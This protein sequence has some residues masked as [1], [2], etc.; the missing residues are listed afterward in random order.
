MMSDRDA[1]INLLDLPQM[2]DHYIGPSSDYLRALFVLM[3]PA[4]AVLQTPRFAAFP[5]HPLLDRNSGQVVV[6]PMKDASEASGSAT[7]NE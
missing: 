4:P 5:L 6:K 7:V 2:C 3:R 1:A